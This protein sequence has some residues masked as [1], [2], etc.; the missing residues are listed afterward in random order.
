MQEG[1]RG[2]ELEADWLGDRVLGKVAGALPGSR[3]SGDGLYAAVR[4]ARRAV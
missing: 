4:T 3:G 2:G 1:P